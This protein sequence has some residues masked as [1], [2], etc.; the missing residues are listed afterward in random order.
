M[1]L[2][3]RF[4]L[5]ALLVFS[6]TS[7]LQAG[8]GLDPAKI[9]GPES[10]GECHTN[11]VEAWKLTHHFSTFNEMHR[12]DEA[13]E[14]AKKL[15]IRRLKSESLCINCHYTPK[16]V[17]GKASVIAGNSCE[18]CHGEAKDWIN[19]HNDYGEF[20][21][22]TEPAAHREAR[23]A[24]AVEKGMMN[25]GDIY[26]VAS[27]C[28]ECHLVPNE[29]LVNVGGHTAGSK[30][31]E[32]VSWM[33]GEVRHNF[34]R[35]DGKSNAENTA[36]RKRM[37]FVMGIILDLEHSLRGTALATEKATYG[38]TMAK[39]SAKVLKK[40]GQVQGIAPTSEV[41]AILGVVDKKELKLN[42]KENLI[43]IADKVAEQ[44]KA[45]AANHDGSA[46]SAL[47]KYV[48]GSDKYKGDVYEIN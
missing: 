21:K 36:E 38:I 24:K 28:Y 29:E 27:N 9:E 8:P 39:R 41:E 13:K 40:L 33:N 32:L 44:G 16:L 7:F 47:D 42:N 1:Q 30:G 23:I 46:L 43:A 20:T 31:F 37:L 5:S 6:S 10:C 3:I 34:S 14:I 22:E 15:G 35:S 17:D 26:A 19:V 45:F 48:P 12:S 4:L 2:R 18:S 11:E 25:P